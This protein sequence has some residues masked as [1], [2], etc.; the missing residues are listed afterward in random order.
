VIVEVQGKRVLA[1]GAHPDDIEFI[2][3]GALL[4]LKEAGCEIHVAT[5][6]LGDCGSAEHPAAEIQRIRRAEAERSCAILGAR[7][8]YGG[9]KDFCIFYDEVSNRRVAALLR[10]VRPWLVITH[11]PGDYLIDHEVTSRLVRNACFAAPTPNFDTSAFS[12]AGPIAAIPALY[13]A[14][15]VEGIDLFGD[16]VEP[17]FYLDVGDLMDRRL[18]LL[19]CHE[20]QR[21]WLRAHHGIDE[22]LDSMRRWNEELGRRAGEIAG[23]PIR[24]AEAFRQHRGHAYPRKN[25]LAD[26]FP[27]RVVRP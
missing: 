3:S 10:E 14:Q 20:S 13:Y 9:F 17:H 12:M 26:L 11:P 7:Y 25:P 15:P 2:C 6:T 19:A 24:F 22:Y 21:N 16:S 5:L 4:L 18:E 1:V 23:R 27:D 8:H